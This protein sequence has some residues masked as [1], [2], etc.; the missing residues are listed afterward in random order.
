VRRALAGILGP[1][2]TPFDEAS[3]E[4][5]LDAF[6]SNVEAHIAAGLDGIVVS[7]STGEAALLDEEERIALIE[8]ARTIVSRTRWLVAG[9][10]GESTR[11]TIRR[12]RDVAA[13]GADAVLVVSP[14]YYTKLM[15]PDAL[16]GHFL[17]VADASPVPLL[18]Y[19]IPVYAHFPIQPDLVAELAEH[20]NI[21]GMKDS[22][23]DL[24]MLRRYVAIQSP[25]FTVL[26]GHG[27]TFASA[28]ELGVSGGILKMSLFAPELTREISDAAGR[29]DW[30][31][32]HRVQDRL[33]PVAREIVNVMGVPAV[34]AALDAIG[35]HGGP[36]RSPLVPLGDE[37]RSRVVELIRSIAEVSVA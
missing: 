1:V 17:R 6:A 34:K 7:G 3:T 35:L 20:P 15:T 25:R 23:G 21:A 28:L 5:A 29:C 26:T 22:A 33:G 13:A 30:T 36:P 11:V 4:V 32:A 27:P 18:L 8:T 12:A 19:N 9:V 31:H 10:G 14:H 24:E 2:V 37:A 16:R